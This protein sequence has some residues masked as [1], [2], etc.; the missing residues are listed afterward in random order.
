M[1]ARESV[2]HKVD[3]FRAKTKAAEKLKLKECKGLVRRMQWIDQGG[4]GIS[5]GPDGIERGS[6]GIMEARHR[7]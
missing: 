2:K 4:E 6:L 7:D 5:D 1:T 3:V